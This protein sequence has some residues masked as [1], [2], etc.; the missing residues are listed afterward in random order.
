MKRRTSIAAFVAA[1]A[2]VA[3]LTGCSASGGGDNASTEPLPIGLLTDLSGAAGIF[4]PP[5]QNAAELAVEEINAAGGV[6]GQTVKLIV[7]DET[8]VPTAGV[9]A[10][11]RL[12]QED[13][14]V[15]L[16]GQHNSA[17][18]DA[19]APVTTTAGIPY[20]HTP[21]AEGNFCSANVISNGEV[22]AQQLAPA[23]PYVQDATGKSKWFLLGADY[24]W[25]QT[26]VAQAAKYIE[27]SGGEVVGQELVPIGTTDFQS[28]I[29][30]IKQSGA[31]LIIPA[32]FGGD[33]ITFEKQAF[34]AGV[35]N[36]AV[37]RLG[38]IYEDGT[39]GAMGPEVTS[40]MY[41]SMAYNE[42]LDTAA[43]TAFLDAYYAKFGADAPPQTALSEQ[44]FVA[45]HAWADAANK[46]K[47][48][49]S[50]DVL[51]ALSGLKYEGPSGTVTFGS[52]HFATQSIV[53]TQVQPDGMSVVVT[54][55]DSVAPEQD[56]NE[57]MGK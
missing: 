26:V 22:P 52:D 17:T 8:G 57:P 46:A 32:I 15:A 31:Q 2:V 13:G 33:A 25:G 39:L 48:T 1:A 30:K 44:T 9:S 14:I 11:Q 40:G 56:C 18:R 21:L 29:T 20:F 55:F 10:A 24:I 5:T 19:V 34:D 38:V 6:N 3:T 35:G 50:A 36:S 12:I 53:L 4:G 45:I 51:K 43:N 16:F 7:A 23:I 47:S 28:V 42:A 54:T 41:V 37:Q 49:K 27:A